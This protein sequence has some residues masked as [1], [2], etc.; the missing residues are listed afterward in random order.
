VLL[1]TIQTTPTELATI[2]VGLA[3][4]GSEF[5]PDEGDVLQ[6]ALLNSILR[7]LPTIKQPATDFLAALK[8]KEAR[9]NN[10]ADLWVDT[11]KY[12]DLQ[13]AKDVST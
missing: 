10:K 2:L 6:S 8:L 4:V 13:D 5:K 11:D 3:R 12:P 7:V 9:D 1:L